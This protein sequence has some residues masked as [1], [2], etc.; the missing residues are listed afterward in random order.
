MTRIIIVVSVVSLLV[1]V[2]WCMR[3]S[4]EA[5]YKV[6]QL[7]QKVSGEAQRHIKKAKRALKANSAALADVI[8]QDVGGVRDSVGAGVQSAKKLLGKS[9]HTQGSSSTASTSGSPLIGRLALDLV[10]AAAIAALF[11][12]PRRRHCVRLS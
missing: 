7:A 4:P 8:T 5:S 12:R 2:R 1:P 11:L 6:E 9:L 10:I 3:T